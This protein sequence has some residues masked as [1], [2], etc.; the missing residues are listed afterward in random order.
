MVYQWDPVFTQSAFGRSHEDPEVQFSA[1][2]SRRNMFEMNVL[3][4]RTLAM[5]D[6]GFSTHPKCFLFSIDTDS[7][8]DW[9][10]KNNR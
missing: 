5:I 9:T 3:S 2:Y 10:L 6:Q 8:G 7:V 1:T 4:N